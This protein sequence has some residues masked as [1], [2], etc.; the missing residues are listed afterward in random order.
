MVAVRFAVC[1]SVALKS[2]TKI[3]L[4]RPLLRTRERQ[5]MRLPSETE[6]FLDSLHAIDSGAIDVDANKSFAPTTQQLSFAF[7]SSKSIC[8]GPAR[9]VRI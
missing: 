5:S 2:F 6:T 7:S 8:I 3:H 9:A 1:A 4:K